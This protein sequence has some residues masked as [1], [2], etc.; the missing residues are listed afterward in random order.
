MEQEQM[1]EGRDLRVGAAQGGDT[2][3]RGHG[4]MIERVIKTQEKREMMECGEDCTRDEDVC[5]R[6]Q[7]HQREAGNLPG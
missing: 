4:K 5:G 7:E 6:K 2:Q 3:G 1:L